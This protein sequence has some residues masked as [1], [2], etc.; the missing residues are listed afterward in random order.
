MSVSMVGKEHGHNLAADLALPDEPESRGP[1]RRLATRYELTKP[2]AVHVAGQGTGR[3]VDISPNG[4]LFVET[5]NPLAFKTDLE[6]HAQTRL[7]LQARF[8]GRV[9]RVNGQGMAIH[10]R[11]PGPVRKLLVALM[12][13]VL[14]PDL[15]QPAVWRVE[16]TE[17]PDRAEV[18]SQLA[19][20]WFALR[21]GESADHQG[22]IDQAMKA[23]ELSFALECYRAWKAEVPDNPVADHHLAHI[24]KIIG[25]YAFDRSSRPGGGPGK[26]RRNTVLM[27]VLIGLA[28]LAGLGAVVSPMILRGR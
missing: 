21:S 20:A 1:E 22:F 23:K 16:R 19:A 10:L 25:F 13:E 3:L 27:F 24:A 14:D 18:M 8:S 26:K 11:T 5:P 9:V 28:L 6:V 2:V 15:E 7:G 17:E 4:G 12:D